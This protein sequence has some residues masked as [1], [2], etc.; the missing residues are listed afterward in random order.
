MTNGDIIIIIEQNLPDYDEE[1]ISKDE[2]FDL[3]HKRFPTLGYESFSDILIEMVRVSDVRCVPSIFGE[4]PKY[5][6]P[7]I[8]KLPP[9]QNPNLGRF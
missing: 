3:V 9:D 1:P 7:G 2:L 4:T 5:T 8:A 6:K